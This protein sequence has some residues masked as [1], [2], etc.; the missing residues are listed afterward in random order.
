[1]Q[2]LESHGSAVRDYHSEMLTVSAARTEAASMSCV[3]HRDL[4]P[5]IPP[6]G[7]HGTPCGLQ[8][9]GGEACTHGGY[10]TAVGVRHA[11]VDGR[12]STEAFRRFIGRVEQ[13]GGEAE[14]DGDGAAE[15]D[16]DGEAKETIG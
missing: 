1:M 3:A 13:G 2:L 12:K 9:G 7:S 14:G 16:G 15:G 4:V 5:G 6:L 10:H 8:G 11:M